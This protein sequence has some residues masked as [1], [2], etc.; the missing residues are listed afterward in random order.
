MAR[1]K[2]KK[3]ATPKRRRR[4]SG[5]ALNAKSPV[6]NYG[7]I[8]AGYFLGQTIN[9]AIQKVV[10]NVAPSVSPTILAAV[11]AGGGFL[12]RKSMKGTAGQVIGGVLMGSGIRAG[13]KA[14]G[15]ISGIPTIGGMRTVAQLP[16]SVR[17]V[18]GLPGS[19]VA[20]PAMAVIGAMPASAYTDR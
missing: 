19:G 13:L 8:A 17:K 10:A 11:Q 7:S 3:S 18:A 14:T 9:D 1:K 16:R 4:V 12:I 6:V 20:S 5:I 2:T 15:I